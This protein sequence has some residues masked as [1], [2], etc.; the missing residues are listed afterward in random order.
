MDVQ[1]PHCDGYKATQLIRKHKDP[2]IRNVL[3]IAMTASAI[4]GDREKCLQS[5]MNNYL[6]KPVKAKTLQ[7][8]LESYLSKEH[9][10]VPNLQ[11]EANKIVKDALSEADKENKSGEQVEQRETASDG[12]EP[13]KLERPRSIRLNTT[14]R[15][16]P[17]VKSANGQSEPGS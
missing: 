6:A 17:E 11:Q 10:D 1:M 7:A 16:V 15:I 5:G 14:Q 13:K 4:D 9:E 3:I 2:T 8:L 12:N